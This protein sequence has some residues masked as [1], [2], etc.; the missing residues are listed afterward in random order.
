MVPVFNRKLC[1]LY[2]FLRY[3]NI[4]TVNGLALREKEN[5][6]EHLAP[7]ETLLDRIM[8]GGGKLLQLLEEEF[9]PVVSHRQRKSSVTSTRIPL[10]SNR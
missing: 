2:D 5:P 6:P 3:L 1:E 4:F 10:G 9:E 7:G 8:A